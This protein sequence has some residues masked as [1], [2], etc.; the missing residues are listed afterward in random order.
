MSYIP[1]SVAVI[2]HCYF[3]MNDLILLVLCWLK[4]DDMTIVEAIL[5]EQIFWI[6]L[7]VIGLIKLSLIL[8]RLFRKKIK[9]FYV[10]SVGL[11]KPIV[12]K[13]EKMKGVNISGLLPK[14]RIRAN[15]EMSLLIYGCF[16]I[17]NFLSQFGL[18]KMYKIEEKQMNALMLRY[19]G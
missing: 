15:L 11:E 18:S 4:P 16:G 14:W 2:C 9:H 3:V 12:G 7:D 8:N 6:N 13:R 10:Y 1:S 5:Y 17:R 19:R